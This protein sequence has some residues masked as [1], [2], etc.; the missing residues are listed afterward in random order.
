MIPFLDISSN[1]QGPAGIDWPTLAKW[2][3]AKDPNAGVIIKLCEGTTYVNPFFAQQR[4]GAEAAGIQNIGYYSFLRPSQGS[5]SAHAD[6]FFETLGKFGG[7]VKNCFYC[8]D[9]EDTN[10]PPNSDLDAF[11]L[12]WDGRM[13][14]PAG[15]HTVFY[16]GSWFTDAHNLNRDPRLAAMGLWWAD[17]SA[18]AIPATPEPW[19][20]AGKGILFWQYSWHGSVPGIVG[21]VDLDWLV[22]PIESL[23]PYQM[24]WAPDPLAG[25]T[26]NTTPPDVAVA[27]N[28]ESMVD[29]QAIARQISADAAALAAAV[30]D[31]TVRGRILTI[32][33]DADLLT[34]V[35]WGH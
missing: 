29:A 14:R 27:A 34:R 8:G 6:F 10:V 9:M 7:A 20:S 28:S 22:G 30:G 25:Q 19:R 5:G 16:S 1:N 13:S 4:D 35:T 33:A 21:D 18:S 24:G 17:P 12:D 31:P 2:L 23:R 15:F 11:V 3:I 32:Q 26:V